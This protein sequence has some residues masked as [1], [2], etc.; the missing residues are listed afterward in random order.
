MT[1]ATQ[2]LTQAL[3]ELTSNA[4]AFQASRIGRPTET[5]DPQTFEFSAEIETFLESK[6]AYSERTR[7]VSFGSY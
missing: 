1:Y 3:Q 6:R 7:D 5:V 2:Q 4:P